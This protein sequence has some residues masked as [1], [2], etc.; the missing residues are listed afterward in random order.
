M[1]AKVARLARATR[2]Y[3]VTDRLAQAGAQAAGGY[4]HQLHCVFGTQMV[5]FRRR[6]GDALG[7]RLQGRCLST[8][9]GLQAA[10]QGPGRKFPREAAHL[11]LSTW[12]QA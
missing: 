4:G 12:I 5:L 6:L 1:H 9:L 8:L 3:K 10:A 2:R 7:P 11:W